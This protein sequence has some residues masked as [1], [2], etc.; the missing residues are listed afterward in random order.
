MLE[1]G[2]WFKNIIFSQS[3]FQFTVSRMVCQIHSN[4]QHL[5]Y[6]IEYHVRHRNTIPTI[7]TNPSNCGPTISAIIQI[8]SLQ[9]ISNTHQP[10]LPSHSN[11]HSV[12]FPSPSPRF[13]TSCLSHH[14][15]FRRRRHQNSPCFFQNFSVCV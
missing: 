2:F 15:L 13:S 6:P 10:L 8:D 3:R 5:P 14:H 12:P 4:I 1:S 9:F 11:N 7:P